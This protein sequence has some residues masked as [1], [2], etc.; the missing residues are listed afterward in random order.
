MYF[1]FSV[2]ADLLTEEFLE[3]RVFPPCYK[4]TPKLK[5]LHSIEYQKCVILNSPFSTF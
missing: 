5:P 2:I 4:V 1:L 3:T